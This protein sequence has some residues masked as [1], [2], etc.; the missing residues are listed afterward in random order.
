MAVDFRFYHRVGE[1]NAKD[2][3]GELDA[4]LAGNPVCSAVDVASASAPSP[5]ALVFVESTKAL[6][7]IASHPCV[8]IASAEALKGQSFHPGSALI[9]VKHPK[10]AFAVMAPR[11]IAPRGNDS[12][13]AIHPSAVIGQGAVISPGVYV[14]A[15]ASIGENCHI[16]PNAVIGTGVEIGDGTHVGA[17]AV[18]G[19]AVIGRNCRIGPGSVIGE[20]GFGL[21]PGPQGLLELPHFG[22]VV[23]GGDVRIGANCTIDRGMFGDTVLGDGVKLD[24][25]CHIAHNVQVGAHT[26]MAAFAGVSGSVNIGRGAQFGGRVGVVDHVTIGDGVRLAANAS[27]AGDVPA[28]ETWAGQPAQPIRSW[29]RELAVLKRLAAPK[30]RTVD[31]GRAAGQDKDDE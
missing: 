4:E 10:A 23:I 13:S 18:I 2:I 7:A 25:L 19:F 26:L 1:L 15:G 11:V 3:A 21:V 5:G 12:S 14:G 28:G 29:L 27:P 22:R 9:T 16:G 6:E 8:I 31:A 30:R 17:C 24:N 20:A